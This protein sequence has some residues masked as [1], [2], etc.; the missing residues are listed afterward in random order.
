MMYVEQYAQQRMNEQQAEREAQWRRVA[1][2]WNEDARTVRTSKWAVVRL[3]E[4]AFGRHNT[5]DTTR[6]PDSTRVPDT[7]RVPDGARPTA[8][9]VEMERRADSSALASGD[10]P[11]WP[12]GSA[13]GRFAEG[14]DVDVADVAD[15]HAADTASANVANTIA[16]D[17]KAQ[18]ELISTR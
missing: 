2:H 16:A 8:C 1:E 6:V 9:V 15:G 11:I 7:T 10:D 12:A 13:A 4:R 5:A 3:V 17:T 14:T 18:A